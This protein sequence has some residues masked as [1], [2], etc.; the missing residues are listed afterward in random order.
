[1]KTELQ[2]WLATS[3]GGDAV[4]LLP[5]SEPSTGPDVFCKLQDADAE[6]KR[7][8]AAEHERCSVLT[9]DMLRYAMAALGTGSPAEAERFRAF[10]L[11][12]MTARDTGPDAQVQAGPTAAR[13]GAAQ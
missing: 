4:R 5:V 2:R 6:I 1:M 7:A 10:W 11:H 3:V 9:D 12:A 13:P 8:V